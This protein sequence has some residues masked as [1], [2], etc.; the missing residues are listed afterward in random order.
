MGPVLCLAF[1]LGWEQKPQGNT[2]CSPEFQAKKLYDLCTGGNAMVGCGLGYR[3]LAYCGWE[4][5]QHLMTW[6][7]QTGILSCHLVL[8]GQNGRDG[9]LAFQTSYIATWT[10]KFA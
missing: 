8:I 5:S 1:V 3:A 6:T 7:F 4:Y 9:W 2:E 10:P